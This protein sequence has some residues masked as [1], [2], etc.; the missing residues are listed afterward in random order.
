LVD[1]C[2]DEVTFFEDSSVELWHPIHSATEEVLRWR[3]FLERNEI[4]QPFKQAHREIYVLTDAE[5]NTDVYSNRFAA[6]VIRQHQFNALCGQRN[7]KNQLRIMADADF[8]APM[9]LLPKHGLRAEFWVE[10]IGDEYGVD[11]NET[12][13]Y[14]YLATDQVR[15]YPQDAPLHY[16]HGYGGGYWEGYGNNRQIEPLALDKIPPLVFSEIMRDV[17]MFVGV[18][19]IG[20]DP[21]WTDGGRETR[22]HDYWYDYSFGDLSATAKTRKEILER[23]IPRLKIAQK[24]SFEDKFLIVKGDLRTYKIHLGSGNILMS[25]NDQYLCIVPSASSEKFEKGKVFLPFEGDRVLSIIL[26]KAFMLAEDTKITD[27]TIIRQI[28]P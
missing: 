12:G 17:D 7:W 18:C 25:P 23:L 1:N 3:E 5:R 20:N 26:S 21:N 4:Q 15:F 6:H 22:H 16:G 9:R 8:H 14:Y 28:K 10:A 27:P 19:S 11:S 24:S 13:T 2:G